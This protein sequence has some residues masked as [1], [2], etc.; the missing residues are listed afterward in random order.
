MTWLLDV[1]YDSDFAKNHIFY[2]DGFP[3]FTRQNMAVLE[4]LIQE[5]ESVIISLN[6]DKP[7]SVNP[8]FEKAGA[9]AMQLLRSAESLGIPVSIEYTDDQTSPLSYIR[10]YLFQGPVGN[11]D[12]LRERLFVGRADSVYRECLRAA[13]RVMTLVQQG[14]RYRDIA[15]VCTDMAT[16]QNMLSFVCHRRN[17][18]LYQSGTEDILQKTVISALLSAMN[19]ALSGFERQDVLAY[20]KSALS[21]L[22][23]DLCDRI[24]NYAYVWNIQGNRWL[25]PWENH[26]DGLV[27]EWKDKDREE[28][29]LLDSGR[30]LALRP[31]A[32]LRDRFR[33][34]ARLSDQ[35]TA[36][37]TFF[38]DIQLA[39]RLSDLADDMDHNGDNRSAQILNQLWDI[40]LS[41]LEQ[42]HDVLG[43]TAWETDTFTRLFTLLLSQY[44][45]GTIPPVL[46]AVSFG[47][48]SAMRCQ[49]SKHLIVLG[50][51]EGALPGYCGSTGVLT[52]QER[53][54]LR[55]MGVPLTGGGMEGLQAE[56]AEI[57]GV[58]CGA[59]E[60]ITVFCGPS[61]PS[62]LYQR[63][64]IM[65][66]GEMPED[67]F[68][69][70]P[71]PFES[72]ACLVSTSSVDAA[73]QLGLLDAYCQIQKQSE[74]S[75]GNLGT[76]TVLDLYGQ[77]LLLSASQIDQLAECRLSYFLKYGLRAKERKEVAVDPA[78]F[79]TY[80]HAVLEHT[81][82]QVMSLGGFHRVSA[83]ET[84][85]IALEYSDKYTSERFS[86]LDSQRLSYLFK[87]NV[88]ELAMVVEELWQELSHSEFE[89]VDFELAFGFG[90]Q[91]QAIEIPG[92]TIEARLRGFVDRVD[93]WSNG[94]TRYF[95][96][97]D[98]KT[99]RKDFDYCDV[100][101]G[102]GLQMLLYLFALED[103]GSSV[104]GENAKSA[105]VQY[106]P[107]RSPVLNTNG[108]LDAEQA[109]EERG[110]QWKR[111]GLILC[112]KDVLN[113][114][115]PEGSPK[116]LSCKFEKD[117]TVTGDIADR[118]QLKLLKSYVFYILRK[119]VDDVAAGNVEPNPYSRGSSHDACTYCPYHSVCHHDTVAGRR[120][121]KAMTSQRFWDQIRKEMSSDG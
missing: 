26:P 44:N 81:A 66:G 4:H 12:A 83:E 70:T 100:F 23:Q 112:D 37:Y 41:A 13:G 107:A 45:V 111:K 32:D 8:A 114:M 38:D 90:E 55:D 65:A 92:S 75:L 85:T 51:Q 59:R 11:N 109:A 80:V 116:R 86:L 98:Y 52:D 43:D 22:E 20:L 62:F 120:N 115:E 102:I 63:L 113:A 16:Y 104:L 19:A 96:V 47:P 121:Y 29:A 7:G 74:Y 21:P 119:L 25:Q 72:A 64:S 5:S 30:G 24:E 42:L 2:I 84:M 94:Q 17:I 28:L 33:G 73:Q 118:E 99:G 56:Y 46:D 88:Q 68:V 87:R 77:H 35:V 34:A 105:G 58:F 110:K 10:Q 106:F 95:R 117:G 14:C 60:T 67:S 3:D 9:T 40:L 57:Y 61:Q 15:V 76:Q 101:N 49:E 108:R 103:N 1:L 27:N 48:I 79:G 89:P 69:P 93:L 97:V 54:A 50:A 82:K 39:Q 6:C 78:E 36:V 91:L 53:D 18:P 71:D 31:L